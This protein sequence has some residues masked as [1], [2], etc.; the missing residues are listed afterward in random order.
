MIK[1]IKALMDETQLKIWGELRLTAA[2]CFD[3]LTEIGLLKKI[4]FGALIGIPTENEPLKRPKFDVYTPLT[5]PYQV[6][7]TQGP[8]SY[9][10]PQ[11]RGG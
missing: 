10:I 9:I 5:K 3:Q 11:T 1:A 8:F 6:I 2:R 4:R 7:H